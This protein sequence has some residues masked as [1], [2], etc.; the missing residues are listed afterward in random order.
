MLWPETKSNPIHKIYFKEKFTILFNKGLGFLLE[1]CILTMLYVITQHTEDVD[2]NKCL[3]DKCI[4]VVYT[5][6]LSTQSSKDLESI[7]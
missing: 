2:H 7:S 1:K 5:S 3:S 4:K 6:H